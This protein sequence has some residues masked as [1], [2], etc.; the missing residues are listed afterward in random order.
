VSQLTSSTSRPGDG[1]GKNPGTDAGPDPAAGSGRPSVRARSGRRPVPP[2]AFL[3]VL[4]LAATAVWI[5]VLR[6]DS[7]GTSAT[8]CAAVASLAPKSVTVTV[9]NASTKQGQANTVT[10]DLQDRGFTT[11]PPG[12]DP[13]GRAVTGVGEIRHG[14]RGAQ[15]AAFVGL[16]LPGATDYQDTR[17]TGTVDLVIGP[18]YERLA[19]QD[20]VAAALSAPSC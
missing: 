16:Y 11:G 9:L 7:D 17:A 20:Q 5:Y 8:S 10:K 2:L 13:S 1:P 18:A 4:A 19:T 15:A 14:A 12:N 3:L 6:S